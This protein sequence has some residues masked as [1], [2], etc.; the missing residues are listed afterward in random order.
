MTIISNTIVATVKK[1]VREEPQF[2]SSIVLTNLM[3]DGMLLFLSIEIN[4][5]VKKKYCSERLQLIGRKVDALVPTRK[6]TL[7]WMLSV[8]QNGIVI[9]TCFGGNASNPEI[10]FV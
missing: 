3:D 7:S 4:Q 10:G 9:D 2:L 8:T 1:I 5:T 6:D